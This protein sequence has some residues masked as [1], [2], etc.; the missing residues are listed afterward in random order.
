MITC[1]VEE[2]P[3][4]HSHCIRLQFPSIARNNYGGRHQLPVS[5]G[6]PNFANLHWHPNMNG[7]RTTVASFWV[8]SKNLVF[9]LSLTNQNKAHWLSFLKKMAVISGCKLVL[10]LAWLL[11]CPRPAHCWCH[12]G[13][14]SP[15]RE[16]VLWLLKSKEVVPEK[17][18]A[19]NRHSE[20]FGRTK[21]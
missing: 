8:Y 14:S 4:S 18:L 10:G 12:S 5:F 19:L 13:T 6:K 21:E 11:H 17:A 9:S 1:P 3:Q 16:P 15:D 20:R 7:P 2:P